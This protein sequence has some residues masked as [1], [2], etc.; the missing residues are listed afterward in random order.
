MARSNPFYSH[1]KD[2]AD[3]LERALIVK[4]QGQLALDGALDTAIRFRDLQCAIALLDAGANPNFRDANSVSVLGHAIES[5]CLE[6]VRLLLRSGAD[7]DCL[8]NATTPLALSIYEQQFEMMHELLRAG[9]DVNRIGT[10]RSTPLHIVVEYERDTDLVRLLLNHG[11]DVNAKD[12]EGLTPLDV[13]QRNHDTGIVTMLRKA[14]GHIKSRG[15][16][17]PK[18]KRAPANCRRTRSQ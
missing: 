2:K 3:A 12:S 7:P 9:A 18:Q 14:E 4:A 10:I 15:L 11:A 17:T 6:A 13:A 1:A 5:K 16:T 8:T